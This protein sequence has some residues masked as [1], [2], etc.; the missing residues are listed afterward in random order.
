MNGSLQIAEQYIMIIDLLFYRRG[1]TLT[2]VSIFS[3]E[4]VL[5]VEVAST[6]PT[7]CPL[8]PILQ[9]NCVLLLLHRVS[10]GCFFHYDFVFIPFPFNKEQAY[11]SFTRY[12]IITL[13]QLF[14]TIDHLLISYLQ[15]FSSVVKLDYKHRTSIERTSQKFRRQYIL[16]AVF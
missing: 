7:R 14:R 13:T 1:R 12:E 15:S 3:N 4:I 9:D 2:R 16:L 11:F 6:K 5:V 8:N 10:H